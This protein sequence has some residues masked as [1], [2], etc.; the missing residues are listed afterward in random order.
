MDEGGGVAGAG[1]MA[2]PSYSPLIVTPSSAIV[3]DLTPR[4]PAPY[5]SAMVDLPADVVSTLVSTTSSSNAYVEVSVLLSD[6]ASP[7]AVTVSVSGATPQ[8][9][10]SMSVVVLPVEVHVLG[11]GVH[12][13]ASRASSSSLPGMGASQLS[14]PSALHGS[15]PSLPDPPHA[16]AASTAPKSAA[17]PILDCF[18]S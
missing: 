17:K 1:T 11:A 6:D 12:A 14:P 8:V 16:A 18:M 13:P 5:L 4:N 7:V 2:R 10:L 15:A 3:A 9:I